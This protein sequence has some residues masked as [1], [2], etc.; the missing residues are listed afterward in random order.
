[1]FQECEEAEALLAVDD[2][3]VAVR[4]KA[5]ACRPGAA[6]EFLVAVK[7]NSDAPGASEQ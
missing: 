6:I 1:V 3:P 4:E 2:H 5:A 7:G